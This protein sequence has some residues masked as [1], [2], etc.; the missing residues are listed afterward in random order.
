MANDDT[1]SYAQEFAGYVPT[2]TDPS[3][4]VLIG[5]IGICVAMFLMAVVYLAFRLRRRRRKR[6]RQQRVALEEHI[7][8]TRQ[9]TPTSSWPYA[10]EREGFE[11]E[12]DDTVLPNID[13][14][15][16]VLRPRAERLHGWTEIADHLQSD[17]A[18]DTVSRKRLREPEG[19]ETD[20]LEEDLFDNGGLLDELKDSIGLKRK[21]SL[22]HDPQDPPG[23]KEED[24]K[25]ATAEIER[26]SDYNLL[27]DDPNN[28]PAS[29]NPNM[30]LYFFRLLQS[31]RET[32]KLLKLAIPYSVSSILSS[33]FYLMTLGVIGRLLGTRELT[34]YIVV[35]N[36]VAIV[37]MFLWG[38]LSSLTTVCS[39]AIGAERYSLAGQYVQIAVVIFELVFLPTFF[40]WWYHVDFMME[41]MGFDEETT[42][43]AQDF[44]RVHY[45]CT[46]LQ[47]IE[48]GFGYLLATSGYEKFNTCS[49][50]LQSMMAWL[51]TLYVALLVEVPVIG[52]A[53]T[54]Q[55][56][57]VVSLSVQI[58]FML[59]NLIYMNCQSSWGERYWPGLTGTFALFNR[60]AVKHFM[61]VAFP[62]SIGYILSYGEWEVMFLLASRLG[63]AE[64]AAWGVLGSIWYALECMTYAWG[65]AAEVR[66][67]QLLGAGQADTARL[68]AHKALA[69]G[70]VGSVVASVVVLAASEQIPQWITDDVVLQ[71]MVQDLLPLVAF[72]NAALTLG[73]ISFQLVGAQARYSLATAVQFVGSWVVTLP[74]AIV[75]T[76][77]LRWNLQGLVAAVVLGYMV[78][79]TLNFVIVCS[80]NWERRSF[81]I[82]AKSQEMD[83]E[84]DGYSSTTPTDGLMKASTDGLM[85]VDAEEENSGVVM[86]TVSKR[87]DL[88]PSSDGGELP[89]VLPTRSRD[90]SSSHRDPSLQESLGASVGIE[91]KLDE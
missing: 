68:S 57:G 77:V 84:D 55:L 52:G 42:A 80:T 31:D 13:E 83:F 43:I 32:K 37:T 29:N 14:L 65:D 74:L 67:A 58:V 19:E 21:R 27:E 63:P 69:M 12:E 41:W 4:W 60:Q 1:T 16:P 90:S 34:A 38:L 7:L 18:N 35:Y 3:P 20:F 85:V 9:V 53:P 44:A 39:Q 8:Q 5:T 49:D 89:I 56:V 72:G 17:D 61:K 81:K 10:T 46:A 50:S 30:C 36:A 15:V 91:V 62:L 48:Y 2:T 51:G 59:F 33:V 70:T 64:V 75:S 86:Q 22:L 78:S 71:L 6:K 40:L 11:V 79:G 45:L 88:P 76:L 26:A 47:G 28:N 66:C 25:D 54:L 87:T 24:Q 23:I 73:S 82:A